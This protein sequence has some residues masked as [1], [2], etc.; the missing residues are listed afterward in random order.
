MGT[1]TFK[2]LRGIL[3]GFVATLVLSALMV[4]KA[5]MGL[6]PDLNVIAMLSHMMG[7]DMVAGWAAHFMI[8]SLLWGLSFA[9][10]FDKLPGGPAWLKGIVFG[11]AAWLMMMLAVMPMAGAGIFGSYLGMMAP[12]MTLMLHAVFGAVMG[13]V[14]A[15]GRS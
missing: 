4:M 15:Q 2:P 13:A 7:S 5:K 1:N 6:M 8:G 3:A 14:Y 11:M 12:V 9:F 10:F